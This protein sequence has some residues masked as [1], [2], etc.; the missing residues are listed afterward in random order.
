MIRLKSL[1]LKGFLS[2]LST[3]LN[4]RDSSYVIIGD[5]ASGKTSILRGI[6]FALFGIDVVIGRK[7]IQKLINRRTNNLEVRLSFL[8]NGKE[9]EIRRTLSVKGRSFAEISCNGKKEA[10]GVSNVNSVV[11]DELKIDMNVFKSTTY[12]PQGE[13]VSFL[14]GDPKER[15]EILNRLMGIDVINEK[16]EIVKEFKKELSIRLSHLEGVLE[17]RDMLKESVFNL[18]KEKKGIEEEIKQLNAELMDLNEILNQ[19]EELVKDYDSR[20]KEFSNLSEKLSVYKDQLISLNNEIENLKERINEVESLKREIPLLK[21]SLKQ[22]PKLKELQG[23]LLAVRELRQK[24]K[25]LQEKSKFIED[26]K[27]ELSL[28]MQRIK[29][30]QDERANLEKAIDTLK[31]HLKRVALKVENLEQLKS[32]YDEVKFNIKNE[33]DIIKEKSERLEGLK[34]VDVSEIS[35]RKEKIGERLKNLQDKLSKLE[36]LKKLQEER[37]ERL[38]NESI[39]QCPLCGSH[40]S[41]LKRRDLIEKAVL[42]IK[43]IEGKI[44]DKSEEISNVKLELERV[45]KELKDAIVK[46]TERERMEIDLNKSKE[47]LK[48][49]EGKLSALKFDP[50][51]YESLKKEAESLNKKLLSLK[52]KVSYVVSEIDSLERIN[53]RISKT[54]SG[55]SQSEVLKEISRL[56]RREEDLMAEIKKAKRQCGISVSSLNELE[57]VIIEHEKAVMRLNKLEGQLN[58]LDSMKR[59]LKGKIQDSKLLKDKIE[60]IKLRI[61]D[62]NYNKEKH[63]AIKKIYSKVNLQAKTLREKIAELSGKLK[64]VEAQVRETEAMLKD[65]EKK[66]EILKKI[67]FVYDSVSFIEKGF[68]PHRGF[69]SKIREVLIPEITYFCKVFFEEFNFEFGELNINEDLTVEFGI[70]GYGTMTLDQLSGGQK[71]AF[72]LSLRFAMARKFMSSLD[73]LMLD[74]PTVHLDAERKQELA[75]LLMKLKGKIPQMIVVTHDPELEIAGDKILRVRKENGVS[76]VEET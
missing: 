24:V 45:E 47:K 67:K 68:H 4:F 21:E 14:E 6:F 28:N 19:N 22:L 76:I 7:N 23:K 3:S 43:E 58:N 57:K 5:N 74:E 37:I 63:D 35:N 59:S 41:D 61:K 49:L 48:L 54:I 64:Q 29:V 73:L 72:A 2:H 26:R 75:N 9:Y 16:A 50:V 20:E 56:K 15:R 51:E 31:E 52:E 17:G 65:L 44:R 25:L 60:K 33:F 18:S 69:A 27:K 40:L 30:L 8:H 1:T 34:F 11:A 71:V 42:S 46:K 39:D 13:L 32:R 53:E 38:G 70:P 62:I 12:V 10:I 55:L 66:E 36:A